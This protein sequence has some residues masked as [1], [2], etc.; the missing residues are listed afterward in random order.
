MKN[1]HLSVSDGAHVKTSVFHDSLPIVFYFLCKISY[2]VRF[3]ILWD[4]IREVK[5]F[6][7]STDHSACRKKATEKTK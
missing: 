7:K 6:R 1:I 2:S 3:N 5:P 4:T